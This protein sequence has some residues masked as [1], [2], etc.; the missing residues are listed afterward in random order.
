[1]YRI[2]YGKQGLRFELPEEINACLADLSPSLAI[3]DIAQGLRESL[4][5]P[6]ASPPLRELARPGDKVCLAIT[7]ASR[8]CPNKLLLPPILAELKHA[9]VKDKDICIIIATGLH[10]PSTKAERAAMLGT[11]ILRRYRVIDHVATDSAQSQRVGQTKDGVPIIINKLA[12]EADLLVATGVVEPH[13]YAGYSGGGKTVAIGLA[14]EETIRYT[15][16]LA[17]IKKDGVSVGNILNNPFRRAVEEIAKQVGLRFIVNVVL[18]KKQQVA[19]LAAG[20]SEAVFEALA[21]KISTVYVDHPYQVVIA[22]VGHPKGDNLY[23]LSRAASYIALN[24]NP[25]VTKGGIIILAA[26]ASEGIG[27]GL[28]E[29]GFYEL[30]SRATDPDDIISRLEGN[31]LPGAQRAYVMART[32]KYCRVMVVG[33]R[34][35]ELVGQVGFIPA[36]DIP[37]A[38]EL[39]SEIAGGVDEVLIVPNGMQTLI[40]IREKNG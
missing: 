38:L 13:Q 36:P 27:G 3:S 20:D 12:Y 1:M 5:Q 33:S 39:A 7:D 31:V 19:H 40:S 26:C 16:S 9:G 2:A 4:Q 29:R 32:L 22:G 28:A 17:M 25:A 11:E 30:M 24:K 34:C 15:H 35:P 8:P 37:R 10:R 21:D 14:G 18:N 6:L 23:Q